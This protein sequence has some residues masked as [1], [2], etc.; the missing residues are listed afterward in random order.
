MFIAP[1]GDCTLSGIS[2]ANVVDVTGASLTVA[3]VLGSG[4]FDL[5]GIGAASASS[6]KTLTTGLTRTA[7]ATAFTPNNMITAVSPTTVAVG[8]SVTVTFTMSGTPSDGDMIGFDTAYDCSNVAPA[9]PAPQSSGAHQ[10]SLATTGTFFICYQNDAG[11][12]EAVQRGV[13]L[14]VNAAAAA[15]CST[16]A[17]G[18]ASS[19]ATTTAAPGSGDDDG[20]SIDIP[21]EMALAIILVLA[22]GIPCFL[23]ICCIVV[24]FK[25]IHGKDQQPQGQQQGATQFV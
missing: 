17:A 4:D 21:I 8:D 15:T 12:A 9:V 24:F 19:S 14:V 20:F 22:I 7:D 10:L 3:A 16:D 2:A 23:C 13:Q 1:K 11:G 5:C 6:V 18:G 25:C